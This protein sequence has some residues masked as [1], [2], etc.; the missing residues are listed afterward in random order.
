[1]KII[2]S[3]LHLLKVSFE[4]KPEKQKIMSEQKEHFLYL[5]GFEKEIVMLYNRISC[6]CHILATQ[7]M[8]GKYHQQQNKWYPPNSFT[9]PIRSYTLF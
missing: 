1:M 7:T 6:S 4:W 2:P 3:K 9:C 5:R 8:T